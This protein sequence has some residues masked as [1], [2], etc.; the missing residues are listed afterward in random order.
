MTY[1]HQT[2]DAWQQAFRLT[3]M[4]YRLVPDLPS[5]E[6]YGLSSQM[7][8]A[9]VSIPSNIAE[10]YGRFTPAE[11]RRHCEIAFGEA[12]ELETQLM[13]AKELQMIRAE[14]IDPVLVQLSRVRALIYQLS[15]S[16]ENRE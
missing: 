13:L 10:G 12:A 1:G 6:K 4:V 7:R 15:K 2:L 11:K 16:Y 5:N 8:R 14:I 9:S 3:T